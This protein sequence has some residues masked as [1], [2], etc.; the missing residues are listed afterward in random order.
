MPC[1][2]FSEYGIFVLTNETGLCHFIDA[3]QSA[4]ERTAE[5]PYLY[6]AHS[7]RVS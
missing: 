6:P 2:D 3:A 5:L 4:A 7:T 1:S